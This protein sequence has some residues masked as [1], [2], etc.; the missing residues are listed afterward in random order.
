MSYIRNLGLWPDYGQY[1]PMELKGSKLGFLSLFTINISTIMPYIWNLGLWPA[2]GAGHRYS[3]PWNY[4]SLCFS[5]KDLSNEPSQVPFKFK[6]KFK[7]VYLSTDLCLTDSACSNSKIQS[8]EQS[9]KFRV[10][11]GVSG[12]SRKPTT[13]QYPEWIH[14]LW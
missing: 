5:F 8:F 4:N 11:V 6:F 14:E 12:S 2:W 3:W 1:G 10:S 13:P 9:V 7:F